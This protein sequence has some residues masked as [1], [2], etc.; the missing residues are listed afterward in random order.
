MPEPGQSCMAIFLRS[1]QPSFV[2]LVFDHSDSAARETNSEVGLTW[3][4]R[5][6]GLCW[7]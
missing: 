6:Q 1:E 3:R 5:H 7:G 4:G 2:D